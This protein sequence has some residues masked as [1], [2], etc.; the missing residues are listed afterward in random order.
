MQ[1]F[2]IHHGEWVTVTYINRVEAGRHAAVTPDVAKHRAYRD[3]A[4][5]VLFQ[6]EMFTFSRLWT[7]EATANLAKFA[8]KINREKAG[9]LRNTF[10]GEV[11]AL[12]LGKADT[13]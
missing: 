2:C 9:A 4:D 11:H 13:V 8:A 1:F 5:M 12:L 3:L 10:T 6:V 7:D